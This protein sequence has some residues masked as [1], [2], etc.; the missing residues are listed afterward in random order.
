MGTD[1]TEERAAGEAARVLGRENGALL[2]IKG[3]APA[4]LRMICRLFSRLR[5]G[6]AGELSGL[7]PPPLLRR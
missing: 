3:S 5:A 1:G 2:W 4:A 7:S 6:A